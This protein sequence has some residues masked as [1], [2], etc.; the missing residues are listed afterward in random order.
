MSLS[1]GLFNED[2]VRGRARARTEP[3]SI[4]LIALKHGLDPLSL[5]NAMVEAYKN[6][7]QHLGALEITYRRDN[8]VSHMF[9]LTR[10]GKVVSQFPLTLDL[11]SD[12]GLLRRLVEDFPVPYR[13]TERARAS[14][15]R[16]NIEELRFGMKKVSIGARIDEIP[17]RKLVTTEYGNQC[18]VSNAKISDDTGTIRLSLWNDQIE[19]LHVGDNVEI[20]NC[21]VSSFGGEQQLRIGRNGAISVTQIHTEEI[22]VVPTTQTTD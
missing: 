17:P 2:K 6:G 10:E 20:E 19:A 1:Y 21:Y 14:N 11:V 22:T 18:F 16:R 3:R 15:Q 12:P 9:L 5:T 13:F 8:K 7:P 4:V